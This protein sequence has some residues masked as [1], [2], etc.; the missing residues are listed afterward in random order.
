VHAGALACTI[1][2]LAPEQ[3]VGVDVSVASRLVTN[4]VGLVL[5]GAVTFTGHAAEMEQLLSDNT[6]TLEVET[7]R[8][9]TATAGS[10]RIVGTE[11][12]DRICG[13]RGADMIEPG[14]G[15]DTVDAGAGN[16]VIDVRGGGLDTVRCGT[17]VDRV[18]ADR[19]DV[20]ASD[21]E[22]VRR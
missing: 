3:S 10:G 8:C 18:L 12:D 2:N 1:G 20:V 14:A 21:C 13:R 19:R 17:G 15:N 22:R 11:F 9:T 16:D 7:T 6:V 5:G 4:A